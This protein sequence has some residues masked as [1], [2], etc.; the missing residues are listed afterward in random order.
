M[1]RRDLQGTVRG[2][3]QQWDRRELR[4]GQ[5]QQQERRRVG[6]LQ[7]V[8]H[9]DGWPLGCR[10]AP[11]LH[12]RV[13][14]PESVEPGLASEIALGKPPNYAVVSAVLSQ[15]LEPDPERRCDIGLDTRPRIRLSPARGSS[16]DDFLREPS[17]ADARLARDQYQLAA[18]AEGGIQ[19]R[20]QLTHFAMAA[21]QRPS[22]LLG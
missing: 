12:D 13:Q 17:L 4:R 14:K 15:Q 11:E 2:H 20:K 8:Q 3:D 6:P 22:A 7:V 10:V 21:D 18:P 19:S 1:L 16:R 5:S 9:K